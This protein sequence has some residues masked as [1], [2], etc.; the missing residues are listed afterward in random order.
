MLLG[1]VEHVQRHDAGNAEFQQLQRQ[2]QVTLKVRRIHH[3]N[4]Q[5]GVAT[6][7]VVTGDLLIERGLR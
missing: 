3:V 5:V 1:N 7:N 6:Q 4:Q 2:V